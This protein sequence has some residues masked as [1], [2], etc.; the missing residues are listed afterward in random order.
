MFFFTWYMGPS[1]AIL[2]DVVAFRYRAT[3][4]AWYI[5]TVHLLGDALSPPIIG[6]VSEQ[7]ELRYAL[8]VPLAMAVLGSAFFLVGGRFVAGDVAALERE[9]AQQPGE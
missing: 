4:A 2:H 5:F 9:V 6:W 1:I 8:L 3:I 7:S